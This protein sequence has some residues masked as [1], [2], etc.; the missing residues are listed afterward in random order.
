MGEFFAGMAVGILL[1]IFILSILGA[2]GDD[3]DDE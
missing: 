2:N 3:Y 1:T